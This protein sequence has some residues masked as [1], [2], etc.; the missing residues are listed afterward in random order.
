MAH[1]FKT[2]SDLWRGLQ[3]AAGLELTLKRGVKGRDADVEEAVVQ[4]LSSHLKLP[5]VPRS[6]SALLAADAASGAPKVTVEL[7]LLTVLAA[8]G[9]FASMMN[10]ILATL[11]LAKA[12]GS[13]KSVS[14]QFKFDELPGSPIRYTLEQFRAQVDR[15]QRVLE[16]NLALP[17]VDHLERLRA[18]AERLAGSTWSKTP[19]FPVTGP[20][21]QTSYGKVN[22]MLFDLNGLVAQFRFWCRQ[23]GDNR[24][25]VYHE[26]RKRYPNNNI[27][28][29]REY[30]IRS[31]IAK[32]GWDLSMSAAIAG[33]ARELETGGLS[34]EQVLKKLSPALDGVE[35]RSRWV[36]RTT[37]QLLDLLQ[38]PAWQKRYELYS[39]WAGTVL[40]RTAH[41]KA[42]SLH[43][44]LVDG[45]LSFAFGSSRLATYDWAGQQFDVWAELRSALVGGS[46]KRKRGIQP[47]FRVTRATLAATPGAATAFVL[48][49]KHYLVPSPGNFLGAANDYA[50]SCPAADVFVVNHGP[51][52]EMKLAGEC[53][54][55]AP[56][57][58]RFFGDATV[59]QE[60]A[61]ARLGMAITSVLF[62]PPAIPAP[63]SPLNGAGV[64]SA[65][66]AGTAPVATIRVGWDATLQDIDLSL[67]MGSGGEQRDSVYHGNRGGLGE[68]PFVWLTDDVR[69]GPGEECIHVGQWN[70]DVYDIVVKNYTPLVGQLSTGHVW[71]EVTIGGS[72][73]RVDCPPY[74]YT[75]E[76]RVGAIE[77]AG[78]TPRL[79]IDPI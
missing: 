12:R 39:V 3:E 64:T 54:K 28:E 59:E 24:D 22:A 49:C 75:V 26:V 58:V 71:C 47:D 14:I 53:N 11:K 2:A 30:W 19:E 32:D 55:V 77:L 36:N 13:D 78:G 38:L 34:E 51:L 18:D 57:R 31:G 63:I 65:T 46:T 16:T 56:G 27:L 48:E 8:L 17:S 20:A 41:A 68:V 44:H 40:L 7:L 15:V 21:P 10:D 76:W 61:T 66:S 70:Y 1:T 43:F 50:R 72:T 5:L 33:I 29:H 4:A 23:F 74:Q 42:D 9:G 25:N 37:R 73:R 69:V 35:R 62:P 79:Q 60:T 45:A 52:D 6:V 67:E